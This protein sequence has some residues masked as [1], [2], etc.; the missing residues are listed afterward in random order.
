MSAASK[1]ILD[2]EA[3]IAVYSYFI[4]H[5]EQ[6]QKK[7]KRL[8][9]YFSKLHPEGTYFKCMLNFHKMQSLRENRFNELSKQISAIA[10][11]KDIV[12]PPP[13]VQNTLQGAERKIP[14]KVKVLDFDYKYDHITPFPYLES[15][16][17]QVDKQ[18]IRV[19]KAAARHLK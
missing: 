14:I 12:V 17:E 1:Y 13:E 6:E 9:H 5:L 7:D 4:E 19:F 8:K 2:S 11:K 3:N 15:I 16:A 18:F 10:L